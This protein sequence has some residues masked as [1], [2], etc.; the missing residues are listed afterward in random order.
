MTASPVRCFPVALEGAETGTSTALTSPP[1]EKHRGNTRRTAQTPN[2]LDADND[3]R[4]CED[5]I[6]E[7]REDL[8]SVRDQYA[9]EGDVGNPQR[10]YTRHRRQEGAPYGWTSL[11]GFRS[12]GASR[13][14][15][16]SGAS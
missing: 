6:G 3:G 16:D 1:T 4:A 14:G 7:G 13:G 9:P 12:R 2:N 8:P 11:S 5:L 15:A 10:R